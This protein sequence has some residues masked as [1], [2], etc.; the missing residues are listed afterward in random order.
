VLGDI[1][2]GAQPFAEIDLGAVARSAGLPPPRRQAV[3]TDRNGRRRYLDADFG[4]F[5]VEVDGAIHLL[6]LTYWHDM[7]RQND[8]VI[9]SGRPIL[10]FS[11]MA[12]RTDRA[13][14][15]RQL[16]AAARRFSTC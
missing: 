3:R 1:E 15:G 6:P 8:I 12:I 11:A 2:G 5:S 13:A 14:V 16:A 10:R 9:G 4:G 7:S